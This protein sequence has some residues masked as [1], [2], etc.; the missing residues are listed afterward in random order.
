MK[1]HLLNAHILI[2]KYIFLEVSPEE[3]RFSNSFN[4]DVLVQFSPLNPW[5]S[6]IDGFSL[7][8]FWYW[9]SLL[10]NPRIRLLSQLVYSSSSIVAVT[11][12]LFMFFHDIFCC[13]TNYYLIF[14]S[15]ECPIFI[16]FECFFPKICQFLLW[17]N[18]SL[19]EMY[20]KQVQCRPLFVLNFSFDCL[21]IFQVENI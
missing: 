14:L 5:S 9:P 19:V 16:K 2:S 6:L 7:G 4:L 10:S 17:E 12:V 3:S 21:S 11:L 15:I 18:Q 20:L 1:S 8:C 13:Q